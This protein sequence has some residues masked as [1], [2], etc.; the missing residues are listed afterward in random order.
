M[1][2]LEIP[3]PNPQ[4]PVMVSIDEITAPKESDEGRQPPPWWVSGNRPKEC[5]ICGTE[6]ENLT[7]DM[8]R[9]CGP[10]WRAQDE[11]D[12][13]AYLYV[14]KETRWEAQTLEGQVMPADA[15]V[16]VLPPLTPAQAVEVLAEGGTF[17]EFV[18][19]GAQGGSFQTSSELGV[20]PRSEEDPDPPLIICTRGG[21]QPTEA[22]QAAVEAFKDHL[23]GI[24]DRNLAAIETGDALARMDD[25]W[26]I[27][28]EILDAQPGRVKLLAEE[29]SGDTVETP[30]FPG[31][32]EAPP[33]PEEIPPSPPG[34]CPHGMPSQASCVTCMEEGPIQL[35]PLKAVRWQQAR[36]ETACERSICT[37]TIAPGEM[38]GYVEGV[39]WCCRDCTV[40]RASA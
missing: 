15:D 16:E 22:D 37:N 33:A 29:P 10:C 2:E 1:A 4:A 9:I 12:D 8:D 31:E 26:E 24:G 34:W 18:D 17:Q 11:I 25:D 5:R 35:A 13:L 21:A 23:A 36:Y 19:L 32:A 7:P 40:R 3:P 39:G 30:S 27:P 28:K 20:Q 38:I 6:I 14:H